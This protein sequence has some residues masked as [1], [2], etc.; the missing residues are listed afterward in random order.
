[1]AVCG[2]ADRVKLL[3]SRVVFIFPARP[4][5]AANGCDQPSRLGLDVGCVYERR[6]GADGD[7]ARLEERRGTSAS[8]ASRSRT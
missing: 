7:G 2:D 4:L 6:P 5:A 8:G 3:L 1:M